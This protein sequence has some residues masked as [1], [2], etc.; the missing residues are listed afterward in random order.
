M[1]RMRM[2]LLAAWRW[3]PPHRGASAHA[4][5]TL[6]LTAMRSG[7]APARGWARVGPESAARTTTAPADT[8]SARWYLATCGLG[9]AFTLAAFLK[10]G[11]SDPL[12]SIG[13]VQ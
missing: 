4:E 12:A 5:N 8:Q 6:P 10:V 13:G 9:V 7:V 2:V 1:V 3:A 11:V